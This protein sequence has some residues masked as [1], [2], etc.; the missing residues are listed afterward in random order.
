[1]LRKVDTQVNQS[2]NITH[3]EGDSNQEDTE[4]LIERKHDCIIFVSVRQISY[5]F[6]TSISHTSIIFRYSFQLYKRDS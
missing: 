1:M 3:C 6:T 2:D 4:S 5:V